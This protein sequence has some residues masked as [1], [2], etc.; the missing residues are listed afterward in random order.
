MVGAM[1]AA[2]GEATSDFADRP[3]RFSRR[4]PAQ[5]L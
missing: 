4:D 5:C 1:I 3:M 2:T